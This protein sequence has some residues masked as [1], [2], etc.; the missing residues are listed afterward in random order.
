MK[1]QVKYLKYPLTAHQIHCHFELI[2]FLLQVW[3]T[4]RKVAFVS[5]ASVVETAGQKLLL[6]L[7]LPS[8]TLLVESLEV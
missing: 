1:M 5:N 3:Q 4:Q 8:L 2:L 7:A 6:S